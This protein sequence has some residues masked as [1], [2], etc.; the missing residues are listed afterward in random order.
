MRA[1]RK[2]LELTVEVP[3]EDMARLDAIAGRHPERA[4]V[5][6]A[7]ARVDL[8]GD[9]PAAARA[10]SRPPLD[11]DLRQQP[12]AGRAAGG[13]AQRAG[14]RDARAL[15][16]RLDRARRSASRSKTCSRPAA[17]RAL[18]ATSSLELGIDMGAD[19]SRR[20]DRGAA[21]GRQRPAAHRPRRPSGRRGQRGRHLP[22]IPRRSGRLRRRR[23]AAM[24]DGARR[25]D[26]L[27]RA[28]RSTCSR[29]RSSRWWR[30]TTGTSTTC[31]PRIRRAAP[32]AELSRARV[33]GR[34]RHA[35]GALSVRRVRRAAAAGHVGSRRAAR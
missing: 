9:P 27:S 17:L 29:S 4:G 34:A 19:R 16:S 32:F 1:A 15:A 30:W 14:G 6:G 31:S 12:P 33:R 21:V 11:A 35:V 28:I 3:V 8:G 10:D 18:V 26:A 25:G 24:H 20:P 5:A 23:R 22:E 2:A 7:V 13:R